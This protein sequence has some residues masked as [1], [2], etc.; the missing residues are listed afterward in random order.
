VAVTSRSPDSFRHRALVYSG[1]DEFVARSA[2]FVREG[3]AGDEPT[4]VVVS[5]EKIARLREELGADGGA[6]AFA[7]MGG[8][9]NPALIIPAWQEFV[10][11]HGA[12]GVRLRGIGEPIFSGR[13][14][15][16]LVECQRH[17]SLLNLA[18]RDVEGFLLLCPYDASTLPSDVI[19]EA[20]RSHPLVAVGGD[21]AAS[22]DYRGVDAIAAPFAEPLP[23]PPGDA[24]ELEFA[25]GGLAGVR[26]F[27]A[28]EADAAGLA[29]D[30]R[31]DIVAAVDE[32]ASNSLRHGGGRGTLRV[33]RSALGLVCQVEDA[34]SI[35]DP[36]VGR[37][38][39]STDGSGGFGLWMANRLC[40][41]LQVRAVDDGTVVRLHQSRR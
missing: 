5:A 33:W 30:R 10:S 38:R 2:A 6:V 11:R 3:L 34:G 17:E 40:D 25:P 21:D 29:P 16:E 19:D 9:G 7:D 22:A 23:A 32:V 36:L 13:G 24:A 18:F 26:R 20:R 12:P 4:L 37:R 27:V 41:L 39:P 8:L 14:P 28:G 15:Q 35:E 31:A 1:E